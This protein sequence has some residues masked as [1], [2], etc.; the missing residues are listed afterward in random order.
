MATA[1]RYI[2]LSDG[3]FILNSIIP[4]KFFKLKLPAGF[5]VDRAFPAVLFFKLN[6]S[7]LDD[8]ELRVWIGHSGIEVLEK[9][10]NGDYYQTIHELI[11]DPGLV[12]NEN[13]LAFQYLGG[14]GT[15]KISDVFILLQG[16][17]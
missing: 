7:K 11:G 10:L 6:A 12:G 17:V 9:T 3:P 2:T 15:L 4:E 16:D 14:D 13:D 8:F 5:S 1:A